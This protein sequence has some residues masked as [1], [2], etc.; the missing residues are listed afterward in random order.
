MGGGD[1]SLMVSQQP[2][3]CS[4]AQDRAGA[5]ARPSRERELELY[6]AALHSRLAAAGER[7]ER[8]LVTNAE[9]QT[10]NENIHAAKEALVAEVERLRGLVERWLKW[11]ERG[12]PPTA[13][14]YRLVEESRKAVK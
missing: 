12:D 9:L 4:P 11:H 14:P 6:I 2:G 1:S 8:L 3:T 5:L 13:D 7:A 10:R